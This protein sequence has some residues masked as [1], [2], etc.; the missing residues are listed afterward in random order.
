MAPN[1]PDEKLDCEARNMRMAA[2]ELPLCSHTTALRLWPICDTKSPAYNVFNDPYSLLSPPII[3]HALTPRPDSPPLILGTSSSTRLWRNVEVAF[4]I[5]DDNR[6][7]IT[8]RN[9]DYATQLMLL[10]PYAIG[11]PCIR[12]SRQSPE[13][14]A[15]GPVEGDRLKKYRKV[16]EILDFDGK[17]TLAVDNARVVLIRQ[18]ASSDQRAVQLY[19]QLQHKNVVEVVEAFS[20][21]KFHYIVMEEMTLC[22]HHLASRG[23][24]FLHGTNLGYDD[25]ECKNMLLDRAGRL[26]LTNLE[27]LK[28][29]TPETEKRDTASLGEVSLYLMQK[30]AGPGVR[31]PAPWSAFLNFVASA[32]TARNVAEL[33]KGPPDIFGLVGELSVDDVLGVDG[34]VGSDVCGHDLVL[35]KAL[36]RVVHERVADLGLVATDKKDSG[37]RPGNR[38]CNIAEKFRDRSAVVS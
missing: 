11:P 10:S 26:K 12:P 15:T 19:L 29:L 34:S 5:W 31:D 23:L 9:T 1:Q 38:I 6:G 3:P 24:Q 17:A 27:K 36:A 37:I 20:S 16:Y 30:D 28:A 13:C 18:F 35:G 8:S 14:T 33:S 32:P 7:I 2:R 25:L 21:R 22:L 4:E